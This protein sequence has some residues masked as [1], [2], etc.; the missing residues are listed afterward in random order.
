MNAEPVKRRNGKKTIIVLAV[1]VI[2]ASF[3][4][5]TF[6]DLNGRSFDISDRQVLLIVTDSM[7]GN[8]T[9]YD[10]DSFPPNTFVMV[11]HLSEEEKLALKVGDVISFWYGSILDHHRI[12][13]TNFASGTVTTHGDNTHSNETVKL[14][15]I[16]GQVVGTNHWLGEVVNFV[17]NNFLIVLALIAGF[18]IA[19][20]IF[21]A[22][23]NGVF[24]KEE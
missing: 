8:V 9:E 2:I 23:K 4:A 20:E 22:Y 10:I 11:K 15:E 1:A 6:H 17:K 7:D 18:A 24:R 13:E 3:C 12:I 19:G 21:R 16:N 5:Y 14:S